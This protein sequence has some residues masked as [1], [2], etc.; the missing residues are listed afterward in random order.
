M[1]VELK[2]THS[3]SG[4]ATLMM[5]NR[6]KRILKG[7]GRTRKRSCHQVGG[8]LLDRT[9]GPAQASLSEA[10]E[11]VRPSGLVCRKSRTVWIGKD[12]KVL[13]IS[14]V[15]LQ[16]GSGTSSQVCR[17]T[18]T[19]TLLASMATI[20]VLR[21]TLCQLRNLNSPVTSFDLGH[22][23][24]LGPLQSLERHFAL[25]LFAQGSIPPVTRWNCVKG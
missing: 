11:L 4:V 13:R 2:R 23:R 20:C 1:E 18:T 3:G 24:R 17:P 16:L 21:L 14:I 25:K 6:V 9:L 10:V 7:F 19:E 22:E 8:S 15:V 5:A 12:A